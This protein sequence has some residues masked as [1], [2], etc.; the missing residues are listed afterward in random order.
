MTQL[1]RVVPAGRV[2]V[3]ACRTR[4]SCTPW[5]GFAGGVCSLQPA[6]YVKLVPPEQARHQNRSGRERADPRPLRPQSTGAGSLADGG[7]AT[8]EIEDVQMSDVSDG[9]IVDGTTLGAAAGSPP[10]QVQTPCLC[11]VYLIAC[12][13]CRICWN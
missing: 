2:P 1:S 7:G 12:A 5:G 3:P 11:F 13:R 8:D 6:A 9:E 10:Q 4:H